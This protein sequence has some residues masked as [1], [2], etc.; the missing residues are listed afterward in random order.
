MRKKDWS[1]DEFRIR[2]SF[3]LEKFAYEAVAPR[4]LWRLSLTGDSAIQA[5][6]T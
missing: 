4:K 5:K 6:R 1:L 3:W 2:F